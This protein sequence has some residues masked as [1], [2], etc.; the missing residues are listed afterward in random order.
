M[1]WLMLLSAVGCND[2]GFD[3]VSIRPTWGWVD[4]CTDVTIGGFG[5]DDGVSATLD[6]QPVTGITLPDPET[7][8]L[9]VG[10]E[11]YAVT[12]PHAVGFTDM[13]V[14]NGDGETADTVKNAFYYVAC[15]G[16]PHIDAIAP[17]DVSAGTEVTISGCGFSDGLTAEFMLPAAPTG[18]TPTSPTGTQTPPTASATGAGPEPTV[19]ASV[20]LVPACSTAVVSFAAPQLEPGTYLVVITDA[21]GTILYGS[22]LC[23]TADTGGGCESPLFLTYGGGT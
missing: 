10:Y 12:A 7:Q 4:G 19:L 2:P 1:Q 5:F 17:T 22:N 3:G 6:G 15:P 8:E 23:D 20:P 11:F 18:T 13:V 21:S 9:E 16:A 14:T